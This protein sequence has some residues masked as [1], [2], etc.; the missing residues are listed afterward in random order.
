MRAILLISTLLLLFSSAHGQLYEWTDDSGSV[1]FSDNPGH[2][3]AKYR[4]RVKIHESSPAEARPQGEAAREQLRAKESFPRPTVE[5][6]AGQP[7]IW[8]QS[9]Y[10]EIKGRL[11]TLQR[12]LARL[13]DEQVT[14]RRKKLIFQRHSDRK[15]LA[16]KTEAVKAKEQQVKDGE[17]ELADFVASAESAGLSL[18]MLAAGSR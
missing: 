1:N 16:E 14:A 6:Y 10:A 7:L 11:E 13:K 3:P 12:E 5:L 18:D 9:S 4:G 8:W 15:F 2:V 17:K